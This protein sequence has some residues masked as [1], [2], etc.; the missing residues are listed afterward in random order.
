MRPVTEPLEPEPTT[1]ASSPQRRRDLSRFAIGVALLALVVIAV[2][3]VL[4][5]Q[6]QRDNHRV[7]VRTEALARLNAC[8]AQAQIWASIETA[9]RDYTTAT[10]GRCLQLPEASPMLLVA[11]TT[12]VAP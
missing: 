4:V 3:S 2:C 1:S 6:I 5:V 10:E 8:L 11:P 7:L 12:T 9:P